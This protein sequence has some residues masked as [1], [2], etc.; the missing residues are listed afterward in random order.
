[1]ADLKRRFA[2]ADEM[3]APD[4]WEEARR[5]S[6]S[7]RPLASKT[8]S[9]TTGRRIV[10]ACTAFA[11]FTGAAVFAWRTF[12]PDGTSVTEPES[13]VAPAPPGAFDDLPAGW[14]ELPAPPEVRSG[15]AT[16]WTG[17]ELL[18]WG[19]YIYAGLSDEVSD[20]DGF[21]FDA[22]TRTWRILPPWPLSSRS[23]PASAWTGSELLVWGGWDLSQNFFDDGAA[24]DPATD[25][26]R[27]LP[28]A[29]IDGRMPFSV[30]TGRELIVWGSR[31]RDARRVDGAAYDP[32]TN[33]WRPIAAAPIE[34]T[35][36]TAVWTGEEMIVLGAALHGGNFAESETAIGEA[37]DPDADTW[38]R[39][40]D[41]E[42]S[43]QASTAAWNGREMIAWDYLNGS[44]AF[45]PGSDSWRPLPDVPLHESECTPQSTA[46]T[47]GFVFGDYCALMALFD[48]AEDAWRDVSQ[49]PFAG[50][51][52]ELVTTDPVILLLGHDVETG[53]AR[54]FAYRPSADET[55][56][57]EDPAPTVEPTPFVPEVTVED[58]LARVDVTFPDGSAAMLVYPAELELASGGIQ[59]DVSYVW[60][61]DPPPRH[62]IVFLNGPPGVEAEFV[63]GDP[64][65]TLP[66]P[67]GAEATVWVASGSQF[68]RHRDIGWWLAYR[69]DSW[70]ILASLGQ[71]SDADV[72]SGSLSVA[73]TE[74]GFPFVTASGPVALAEGFGESEGPVLT[75]GDANPT[76]DLV[77]DLFD[78]TIFLSADGCTGGPEFDPEH[79][80]YYGSNCL[81]EG[82]VFASI[83][84]DPDFIRAVLDGLRVEAFTPAPS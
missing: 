21:A 4:L 28:P 31:W 23:F 62:P 75:I 18:V 77:S 41:S 47:G 29:P 80:D 74:T 60:I 20:D 76:P 84:G 3:V 13:T 66:L 59:P 61:D 63:E 36:A 54:M 73:E 72:L 57:A 32:A 2:R 78:G 45:D 50:W 44:A 71:E 55:S 8:A 58:D 68:T 46:S 83:Y 12:H 30:W 24:Y 7:P 53:E 19:G 51:G 64:R 35:D 38:R 17:S 70:T 9:L 81:G 25:T 39:I 48:P 40:V 15:A 11:V 26:W 67:G 42:L 43:P 10:A 82:S 65:A 5:L 14:T 16:A 79:L 22:A 37:Y 49:D 56:P 69:T 52:F 1:M 6:T 34:L 33:A 27:A